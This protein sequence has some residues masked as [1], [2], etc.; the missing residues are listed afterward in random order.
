MKTRSE[1]R[2]LPYAADLMYRVVSDV[3]RYPEFLPWVLG[4]RVLKRETIREHEVLYAEMAVGFGALR[5]TY[6]SRVVLDPRDFRIDVTQTE[7]PFNRLENHWIF[8]PAEK[9]C[10]VVFSIAFEFRNWILNT[11]AGSAFE[12]VMLKMTDA[13]EARAKALSDHPVQ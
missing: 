8:T 11:I 5:E 10:T 13:F 9:G 2:K 7:G 12:R 1:T 6:T 4:L 3:E